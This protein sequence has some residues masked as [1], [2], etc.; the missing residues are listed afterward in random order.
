M[1][2]KTNPIGFRLAVNRNW[3]SRWFAPKNEFAKT[4][5]EDYI[6]REKLME[7]LKYASVPRIFIERA[8]SRV[9][10]KIFTARP[11]IVIGRK[12]QEI[13]KIKEELAVMTGREILLDIQEVKKPELEAKLVA[14]NV[15]LQLERRISFRRAM[16]KAVQIA[17]SLGAEG[18]KVQVGGRLGGAD[19]ARTE[20]QRQGS[21]PLHTLR[22]E[23]DYGT[24]EARTVYG[25]IGVKCWVFK[26]DEQ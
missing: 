11:G 15:A 2:Q 16:K 17:M 25:I 6:I 12:G 10:V 24:S 13:E 7:K 19:I 3:Q 21:V 8:S 4:L 14:D 18:I 1:G 20:V 5:H 22:E 9:R 26:K 23:I